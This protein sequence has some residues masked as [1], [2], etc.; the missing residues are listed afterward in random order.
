MHVIERGA[1][2]ARARRG[3]A[4]VNARNDVLVQAP[5]PIGAQRCCI[6]Y[7]SNKTQQFESVHFK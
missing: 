4:A 1:G 2:A 5:E 7:I 3:R 6:A